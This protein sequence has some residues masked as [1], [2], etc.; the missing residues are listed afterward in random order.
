MSKGERRPQPLL[1]AEERRKQKEES[2]PVGVDG[3]SPPASLNRR[4]NDFFFNFFFFKLY[5]AAQRYSRV[6][7]TLP[8]IRNEWVVS[9]SSC[10]WMAPFDQQII[11]LKKFVMS[12][13]LTSRADAVWLRPPQEQQQQQV[14]GLRK[15]MVTPNFAGGGPQRP[16]APRGHIK[17]QFR[18]TTQSPLPW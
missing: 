1:R 13:T 15:R 4:K 9:D 12:Q 14:P 18:A 5:P 11:P 3:F 7:S 16:Q 6:I 8:V 10:S 2:L 17:H